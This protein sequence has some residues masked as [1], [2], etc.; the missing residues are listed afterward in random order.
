MLTNVT[1]HPVQ[2]KCASPYLTLRLVLVGFFFQ[3]SFGVSVFAFLYSRVNR[4]LYDIYCQGFSLEVMV[5][6]IRKK[7]GGHCYVY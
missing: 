7:R 1:K 4:T 5:K 6:S 3:V 2:F